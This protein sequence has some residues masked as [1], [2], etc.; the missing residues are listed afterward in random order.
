M[1]ESYSVLP[2]TSEVRVWLQSEGRT[3]PQADG[4]RLTLQELK[5]VIASL[6]DVTAQWSLGQPFHDGSLT[7]TSG[8]HTTVVVG[9]PGTDS[10]PCEF[11]FRGGESEFIENIV[12]GIAAL[13]G[14]Q[15]IYAHSGSFIHVVQ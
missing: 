3:A 2:V 8:L 15:V 13:A 6:P 7:S 1:S 14:P 10:K 4:R 12:R 5:R 9:E 11:H